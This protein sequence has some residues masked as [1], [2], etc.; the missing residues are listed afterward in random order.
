VAFLRIQD[1]IGRW[2]CET[3]VISTYT[4]FLSPVVK[5]TG[6][7][8]VRI[9]RQPLTGRVLGYCVVK[10]FI[11]LLTPSLLPLESVDSTV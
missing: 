11:R 10:A 1:L 9:Q 5:I 8:S 6:S 2:R 7:D 4:I 3:L